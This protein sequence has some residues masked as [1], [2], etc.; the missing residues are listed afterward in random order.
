MNF[1]DLKSNLKKDYSGLKKVKVALLGD[2][3]TQL[4]S[5]ALKG[6]GFEV[7]YNFD[8][9]E[10]DYDQI[11]MQTYD[12]ESDLYQFQPEYVI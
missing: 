7:G 5:K 2:S 9:W 8:I 11:E 3:A 6:N 12:L 10:A 4:L 1:Y